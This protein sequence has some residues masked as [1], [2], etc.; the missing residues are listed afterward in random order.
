MKIDPMVFSELKDRDFAVVPHFIGGVHCVLVVPKHNGVKF[1]PDTRI[2]RSSVWTTEGKLVSPGLIKFWNIGEANEIAADPTF[3]QLTYA[4]FTE[5]IDGS[6]L[7]VSKFNGQL[8]VRTRGSID[9]RH[10]E[11]GYEIDLLM[12]KY[13][14]AF[15]TEMLDEIT[16]IFEWVTPANR[17]VIP[18]P[19]PDIYLIGAISN[20]GYVMFN[21]YDLNYIATKIGVKR[22][23]VFDLGG[24][25]L[26][27]I[28]ELIGGWENAE[29]ICVY[30]SKTGHNEWPYWDIKKIKSADYLRRHAVRT[31]M[32]LNTVLEY[33]LTIG[34]LTFADTL[35]KMKEEFDLDFELVNFVMPLLEKVVNARIKINELLADLVA[36]YVKNGL[37]KM[38]RKD[39]AQ[40]I[41][42]W[43]KEYSGILFNMLDG[44]PVSEKTRRELYE[45]F[46]QE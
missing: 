13:P 40:F 36:F 21:Q 32:N 45:K 4:V 20:E 39:A 2:F 22:P 44:K 42:R 26:E 38:S 16:L 34:E 41:L 28:K 5:K 6:T 1:T 43:R 18:Y 15:N 3:T 31:N 46:L 8:I 17:I 24:K 37:D 25:T 23:R 35:E 11:N 9:A 29:G 10:M 30:Y 33:Y 12:E 27:E 7:I 19:E 14:L